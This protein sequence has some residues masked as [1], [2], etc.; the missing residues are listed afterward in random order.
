MVNIS[1]K[2]DKQKLLEIYVPIIQDYSEDIK[3]SYNEI[4]RQLK[5][6]FNFDATI[7]DIYLYFEPTIFEETED[8]E[9]TIKNNGLIYG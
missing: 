2:T 8:L 5:V 6:N 9:L 4:I 1:K 7:D 3:L